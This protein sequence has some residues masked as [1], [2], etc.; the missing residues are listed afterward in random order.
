MCK[1]AKHGL[2]LPLSNVNFFLDIIRKLSSF[3]GIHQAILE[4]HVMQGG[5]FSS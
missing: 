3:Q 4:R 2:D 1:I 5:F